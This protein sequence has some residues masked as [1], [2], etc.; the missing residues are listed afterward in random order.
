MEHPDKEHIQ[1]HIHHTGEGEVNQRAFGIACGPE[2]GGTEV[3]DHGEG[4]AGKV[5][6]HIHRRQG[7]H[8]LRSVHH[9]QERLGK[10]D[11]EY[12]EHHTTEQSCGNGGVDGAV[13]HVVLPAAQAVGHAHAGSHRQADEEVDHQ[14]GNGAGG[15]HCGHADTAA[16]PP[17]HDQVCRI[18]QQLK[19]AGENDGNGVADDA[20][21]QRPLEHM[22]VGL[23][24]KNSLSFLKKVI[25]TTI[26]VQN[27]KSARGIIH[28]F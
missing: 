12:R 25:S 13:H 15:T 26:I 21:K 16:E 9:S 8:R 10:G 4:D 6:F 24:Q 23:I 2:N 3:V 14:V 20:A 5:D 27:Y 28:S 18:K 19:Q 7:E 1:H 11:A 22:S 17:H